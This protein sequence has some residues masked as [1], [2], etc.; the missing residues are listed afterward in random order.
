LS[1][2]PTPSQIS[3]AIA[4]AATEPKRATADGISTE[5]HDIGE[6]VKAAEHVA[7]NAAKGPT[8]SFTFSRIVNEGRCG[9]AGAG[10]S[11]LV[12]GLF[13]FGQPDEPGIREP[14]AMPPRRGFDHDAAMTA[15]RRSFR[16][17]ADG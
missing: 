8:R 14:S 13:S 1:S 15:L 12:R 16:P 11:N 4:Q 9:A 10:L 7:A 6:L 3:D 5:M 17:T 2:I